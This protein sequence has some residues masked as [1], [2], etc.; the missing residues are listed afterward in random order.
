MYCMVNIE[1]AEIQIL[2]PR[3][4]NGLDTITGFVDKL[5]RDYVSQAEKCV[6]SVLG[7][8]IHFFIDPLYYFRR[9]LNESSKVME[10]LSRKNIVVR[11]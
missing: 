4:V 6:F 11:A 10:C 8:G 5:K 7:G 2:T 9:V 3:V 1:G